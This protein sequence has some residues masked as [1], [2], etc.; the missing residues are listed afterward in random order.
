MTRK[1]NRWLLAAPSLLYLLITLE[2]V[3]MISPFALYF[4]SVYGPVLDFFHSSPLLAWSTEFFLPHMVFPDDGLILALSYLQLLLPI[5]LLLFLSAAVPLYWGRFT[6]KGVVQGSFYAKIRHPQYLFLAISGLGLLL[7]W[8]RFVILIMYVTMLYVYY[9]LARNEE[10]RM[11]REAPGAYE[12][13]LART[14][15]FLP[16]EPGG[17]LFRVLFGRIRPKAAGIAVSYVVALALA[18]GGAMLVRAY[19]VSVLP[20]VSAGDMTLLPVFPRPAA[21]VRALWAQLAD[22]PEVK[23]SGANM[24]YIL[25]SDFFLTALVTDESRRFS[26]ELDDHLAEAMEWHRYKFKGGLGKFFKIFF[27]FVTTLGTT[28]SGY[29][30]ERLVLVKV[31][32][33]KG[34]PVPAPDL[35]DLG[36]RRLPVL[37]MDLDAEEHRLLTSMRPQA[38]H[39]WGTMPMPTF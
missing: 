24:V 34:K 7:Y 2:I 22:R 4:Y 20:T 36:L 27:T 18:V 30:I 13:Y 3:I 35:F 14:P 9:L 23:E 5:G 39:K 12:E 33:R 32:D 6:G 37:V 26:Y 16:G 17:R 19:T 21:E 10:G 8:P 1:E 31:T 11:T 29:D 28:D 15:M 25:P 38:R